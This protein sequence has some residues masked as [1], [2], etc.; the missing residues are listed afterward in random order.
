MIASLNRTLAASFIQSPAMLMREARPGIFS[1]SP[2]ELALLRRCLSFIKA[3]CRG[4]NRVPDRVETDL[5][6]YEGRYQPPEG[7]WKYRNAPQFNP[8]HANIQNM[9][10]L[11]MDQSLL[12]NL[13][14]WKPESELA[15]WQYQSTMD[16]MLERFHF[17][18]QRS[19]ATERRLIFGTQVYRVMPDETTGL[20]VITNIDPRKFFADPTATSTEDMRYCGEFLSLP[21]AWFE[22]VNAD[23]AR[24]ERHS[25]L[26]LGQS[27]T[28]MQRAFMAMGRAEQSILDPDDDRVIA[29]RLWWKPWLMGVSGS[30]NGS[31]SSKQNLSHEELSDRRAMLRE[32]YPNGRVTL[33][34][35]NAIYTDSE[36]LWG[37]AGPTWNRKDRSKWSDPVLPLIPG[38]NYSRE[39]SICG[40]SEIEQVQNAQVHYNRMW[41]SI[42]RHIRLCSN[43]RTLVSTSSG[44]DK[45]EL[46]NEEGETVMVDGPVGD[47]IAYLQQPGLHPEVRQMAFDL[48]NNI[49]MQMGVSEQ[50]Q[51]FLSKGEKT[52]REIEWVKEMAL[53]RPREK[54]RNARN[55]LQSVFRLALSMMHDT[56]VEPMIIRL[57]GPTAR[58]AQAW[59]AR[60]GDKLIETGGSRYLSVNLSEID[61]EFDIAIDI[62]PSIAKSRLEFTDLAMQFAQAT[63]PDSGEQVLHY[64][65][66]MQRIGFNGWE[67]VADRLQ[68]ARQ[69]KREFL[70][71]QI[72]EAGGPQAGGAEEPPPESPPPGSAAGRSGGIGPVP[73]IPELSPPVQ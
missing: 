71:N 38:R 43:C 65:D 16:W 10:A 26:W 49:N 23:L 21:R 2:E 31:G 32:Q 1:Q 13:R 52:A 57:G 50:T 36:I 29:V 67:A 40:Q 8:I 63:D 58:Q 37:P 45:D 24:M 22:E 19:Q 51:G 44:V 39:G 30:A 34:T 53:N 55:T 18:A 70:T 60:L 68:A 73:P 46:T 69:A 33:L 56:Q 54:A 41:A 12:P 62:G 25:D 35:P 27:A 59:S 5:A 11:E 47:A 3:G 66:V 48:L 15:T 61:P 7:T 42:S 28:P 64:E 17:A 72:M 4:P 14:S 6:T 9:V 20:P